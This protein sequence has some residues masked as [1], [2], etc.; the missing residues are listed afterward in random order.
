MLSHQ[1]VILFF[2]AC[3][4]SSFIH[5]I[6]FLD[7]IDCKPDSC[8]GYNATCKEKDGGGFYCSCP[9]GYIGDGVGKHGCNS[10]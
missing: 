8:K 7:I 1:N 6:S 5:V 4:I 3:C 2:S 9:D 10:K